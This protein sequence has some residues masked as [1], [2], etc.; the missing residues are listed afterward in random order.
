M[1]WILWS[2][3]HV[4][5]GVSVSSVSEG[6]PAVSSPRAWGCFCYHFCHPCW[7][8]VFPTC[9]GVFLSV[10]SR[11]RQETGLPHVRGGVSDMD[12]SIQVLERSS[13]RAWGCFMP[14]L[15]PPAP[16]TVFPTCVG[17]FLMA[18][19]AEAEADSLP[20]VRGGVSAEK[21]AAIKNA[22][23]SPRAWGCF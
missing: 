21:E 14:K 11:T 15:H 2:L 16:P 4:R 23:S 1:R 6:I 8:I 12:T 7:E 19:M 20:H 5:G 17:V 22:E 18:V 3:P 10:Y 9:V 13:P